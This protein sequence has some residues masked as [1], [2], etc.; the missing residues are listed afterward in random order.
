MFGS[1]QTAFETVFKAAF[2]GDVEI[3]WENGPTPNP[4]LYNEFVRFTVQFGDGQRAQI[5]GG[6]YRYQ[7]LIMVQCFIAEGIGVSRGVARAD[8]V[9]ALFLD[10]IIDGAHFNVPYVTKVPYADKGWFQVQVSCPFYFDE[11]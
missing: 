6:L 4:G 11:A 3:A 2:E 7:G 5:G 10:Q 8:E 1:K 9:S